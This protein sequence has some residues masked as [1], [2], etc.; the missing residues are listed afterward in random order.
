M[1]RTVAV[2]AAAVAAAL[3][4][5][6]ARADVPYEVQIVGIEDET[7]LAQ[8]QGVSTLVANVE[9]PPPSLPALK[10]RAEQ[11]VPTL[12]EAMA[13]FGYYGA[14]VSYAVSEGAPT[15]V[16][17]TIA[18]GPVYT[19]AA[20]DIAGSNP[21]LSAGAIDVTAQGLGIQRNDPAAAAEV[22]AAE[23][24]LLSLLARQGYPL[25]KVLDRRIVVD[26]ATR[27]MSVALRLDT[28]PLASFGP[29]AI[30]G[31]QDVDEDYLRLLMP[32]SEG[33]TFDAGKVEEGRRR[34]VATG[35]FTAVRI[36]H[37]EETGPGG[38][39]PM[40]LSVEEAKHRSIGGGVRYATEEGF[41]A[42]VFWEHRNLLGQGERLKLTATGGETGFG[43][44]A[45]FRDPAFWD[46]PRNTLLIDA[47][48]TR[49]LLE[50][51]E[52][53]RFGG[54][55]SVERAM[56]P[57]LS[58]SAGMTLEY[59]EIDEDG[60]ISKFT[61][62]GLPVGLTWDT[63]DDLLDP[64][65]GNK[66]QLSATPYQAIAGERTNFV[67][68]RVY[69]SLYLPLGDAIVLANWG[70]LGF[71]FGDDRGDIP[72]DKRLY[73]GG[74]GSVRGFGYQRLGPLDEDDDPLG[75]RSELGFGSE[76]RVRVYENFGAVVFLEAGN[77][78]EDTMP[79]LSEELLWGAGAGF[80]YFTDFGPLR[81]DVAVPLNARESDDDFQ[82]YVSIGQAF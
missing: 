60:E 34:L 51:F 47:E 24:R 63:S 55:V 80:R 73:G 50:A 35:L 23:Q 64:H 3:L 41:G 76:L 32:W 74:G 66:L 38:R 20:Y 18:P 4:A 15:Q 25:A 39:L 11:D 69:D 2:L 68:A 22:V 62:V 33:E 70:R 42:Q 10:R 30:D 57:E 75:G 5:V 45:S 53:T 36:A 81:L 26:H 43:A 8:L 40:T 12:E 21:A 78:Y 1:A 54:G 82:I 58:V 49:E 29:V 17:V 59:S 56:T 48:A 65:S 7:L 27:T 44:E 61:L 46:D 79:D 31:L 19:L 9:R 14:T 13:S 77:V 67:V 37:A 71:I 16:T 52:A 72:A 28:G 6:P